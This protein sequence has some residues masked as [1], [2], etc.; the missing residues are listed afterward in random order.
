MPV[1]ATNYRSQ[2]I[3][4]STKKKLDKYSVSEKEDL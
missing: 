4:A 3:Q 2:C 1:A